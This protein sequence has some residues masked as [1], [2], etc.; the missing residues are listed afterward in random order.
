M[1]AEDKKRLQ[2]AGR[3][4]P[5]REH[6]F[7]FPA[8][9][10]LIIACVVLSGYCGLAY[11][12]ERQVTFYNKDGQKTCGF[13]VE[14]AR[15]PEEQ[16][17]GLMFRERLPDNG[18][19]LFL[20]NDEDVRYFWM[21]NTFIS[22]DLIFLSSRRKVVSVF[23]SARPMDETTISSFYP[24]RYVLEVKAGRAGQCGIKAGAQARFF[25]IPV[26]R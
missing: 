22:L 2:G 8:L 3:S 14:L 12:G 18:G 15:T 4:T 23:H 24:A 16:E 5:E 9:L 11:G 6:L 10:A 19:M 1:S 21:K 7:S 25:N 17:R 26:R 13:N 20:Y